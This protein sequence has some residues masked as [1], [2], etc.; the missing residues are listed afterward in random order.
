MDAAPAQH[1]LA[2]REAA[3]RLERF[4]PNEIDATEARGW[5]RTLRGIASEP[6]FGL[7]AAA[8]G[9]YLV[10]GDTGEGL[11]LAAFAGVT[12]GLVVFQERRSERALDALRAMAAP[13][14]R[15]IRDG[16]VERIPA[17]EIVPGDIVLVSEG[18]RVAADA[19]VRDAVQLAVDESLLTGESAPV[20]KAPGGRT[21]D[22]SKAV[23]GGE[24]LPFVFAGTLVVGGHGVAEVFATGRQTRTGAIG[25]ARAA[26]S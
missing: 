23:P 20:R 10:I 22:V 18:E 16:M 3:E 14:A 2:R 15:V 24:D 26:L 12:V 9:I 21:A 25:R 4:G 1:G 13:R 11:L 19:I 17:R 8:A 7:L 5:A 6:M